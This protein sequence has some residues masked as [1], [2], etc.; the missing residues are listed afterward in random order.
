M[1]IE[2]WKYPWHYGKKQKE[3]WE[4]FVEGDIF[5]KNRLYSFDFHEK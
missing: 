1:E 3:P 2:T 4:A 5:V